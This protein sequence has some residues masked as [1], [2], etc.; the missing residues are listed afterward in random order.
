VRARAPPR[1]Y[2]AAFSRDGKPRSSP[3]EPD[4]D[5]TCGFSRRTPQGSLS[6]SRGIRLGVK[7]PSPRW[8]KEIAS[9]LQRLHLSTWD[10][11]NGQGA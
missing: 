3:A 4:T 9:W 5:K 2:A 10:V 6:S 7:A 11:G 1:V 8:E